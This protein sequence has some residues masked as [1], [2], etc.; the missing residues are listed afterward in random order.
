MTLFCGVFQALLRRAV[1]GVG[2]VLFCGMAQA[3]VG[4]ADIPA[5][6][7][8]GPVTVFYPSS[9]PAQPVQR[10]PFT[11]SVAEQGAPL[12]GNGRL[13][14]IS[15]GSPASP[16]VHADLAAA[17]VDAGFVVALPEHLADNSRDAS[18]AGQTSWKRRPAEV[19][20]AI[21]VIAQDA[22]FAP[23]LKLDK[24]GMFGMSAGGHTALTLA[25]GRWSPAQLRRHCEANLDDDFYA[26]AGPVTQLTGG[27]FDGLK[28][29]FIRWAKSVQLNDETW[30]AHTDPRIAAIVA[31]VPFAADFDAASL[32][33]PRVP[34]GMIS[35]RQDKWLVAR[36]HSDRILQACTT[37]E[38]LADLPDGGH[39]ALLSP[40][41]PGRSGLIADLVNDPPGFDRARWVPELNRRITAFFNR[42]FL[43]D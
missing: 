24:V 43:G 27:M 9:N 31:G 33:A 8:H 41:L 6:A 7:D 17:L 35:A 26:C 37:C 1:A 30:Y 19:S 36:F 5:A 15:H 22:R 28:K 32:A 13:I 39:G 23:L 42:H 29:R 12:R 4:L 18:D 20:K 3:A 14:V 25:G 40:Q 21:D 10:G 16:W 34:L 2:L 11:L 38:L